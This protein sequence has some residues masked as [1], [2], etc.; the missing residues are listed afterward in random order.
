MSRPAAG[1]SPDW[2]ES[3]YGAPRP[4]ATRRP[5]LLGE[6]PGRLAGS[7]VGET[8][9]ACARNRSALGPMLRAL[10]RSRASS[11]TW[12]NLRIVRTGPRSE[13]G[14]T[15]AWTLERWGADTPPRW[16]GDEP[17]LTPHPPLVDRGMDGSIST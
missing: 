12:E 14:G 1:A 6:V 5:R 10:R 17:R 9:D 16:C 7:E 2:D 11:A 4:P 15:I 3:T 13:R 8:P